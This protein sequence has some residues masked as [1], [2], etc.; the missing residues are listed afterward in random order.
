MI[1]G[2]KLGEEKD[3]LKESKAAE[4][5]SIESKAVESKPIWTEDPL[6]SYKRYLE[7]CGDDIKKS[8][9]G[10]QEALSALSFFYSGKETISEPELKVAAAHNGNFYPLSTAVGRPIYCSK[11]TIRNIESVY[12]GLNFDTEIMPGIVGINARPKTADQLKIAYRNIVPSEFSQAPQLAGPMGYHEYII[13]GNNY[14]DLAIISL[15]IN[16]D[17]KMTPLKIVVENCAGNISVNGIDEKDVNKLL[18]NKCASDKLKLEIEKPR[19]IK[20]R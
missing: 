4:A 17:F 19:Q 16:S 12:I 5:K 14:K 9:T 13:D 6:V 20:P 8:V 7:Y 15:F 11:I 1:S 10:N 2:T 3:I 18:E